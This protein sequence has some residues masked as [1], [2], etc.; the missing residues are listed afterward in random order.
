MTTPGNGG[1]GCARA[2]LSVYLSCAVMYAAL[3]VIVWLG[4]VPDLGLVRAE[5]LRL[6]DR[7]L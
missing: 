2:T 3:N 5:D 7:A 1:L 6:L 4:V